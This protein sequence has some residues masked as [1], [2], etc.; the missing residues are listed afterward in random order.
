MDSIHDEIVLPN[1]F[2]QAILFFRG[3]ASGE[4][5]PIRVI[6]GPKTQLGYTDNVTVD[7]VH[8]E[9]FAAEFRSD[10]ILV[11]R[12]DVGGDVEP[13]R[14]IHG[15]K[16]KL[17]R[18]E[19]VSV[20]PVNNLLA[21]T[22]VPGVWIF[23]RTDNGDVAPRWIIAG[24]KTGIGGENSLLSTVV[25]YPEKK[26]ILVAGGTR[27]ISKGA[28][29][30]AG[31]GLVGVWKYGDNGDVSP[32]AIL[33]STPATKLKKLTSMTLNPDAKELIMPS[34][35]RILFYHIPEIF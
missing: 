11:F 13:I 5:P 34:S 17:D 22:T 10:A 27:V 3:G 26:E 23:N 30:D 9:V 15:P 31:T 8:N 4:E 6:Q 29:N 16:T 14:I 21:V 12:R 33:H 32:W 24:P 7:P 1:P 18:P 35:G 25:L 20:D 2:A 19:K 28:F